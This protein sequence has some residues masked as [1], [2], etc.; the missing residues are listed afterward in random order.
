MK[1]LHPLI[2]G[3][4]PSAGCP[5]LAHSWPALLGAVA[6]ALA[7]LPA[8]ASARQSPP[9]PPDQLI[10]CPS[11]CSGPLPC[12]ICT[13]KLE[14][15]R[16]WME[17]VDAGVERFPLPAP[18]VRRLAPHFPLL[19]LGV[20]EVGMTRKQV[21]DG[22]T[23]CTR[24]YLADPAT[25]GEIQAGLLPRGPY[26]ELFL[27]ELIHVE[28]CILMGGRD[29]Y[30]LRWFGDLGVGTLALL[31]RGDGWTDLHGAMPMEADA[32]ARAA[33][34]VHEVAE[35]EGEGREP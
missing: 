8:G 12:R 5:W 10:E 3:P 4:G 14:L 2:P 19:D 15:Y 30:A 20:V 32:A 9:P 29:A 21:A 24:V 25:I 35:G 11:P 34:L 31:W 28:Q 7:L 22:I 6:L 23:D 26:L 18:L 17:V 33:V 27:H 1:P 13:L 16:E